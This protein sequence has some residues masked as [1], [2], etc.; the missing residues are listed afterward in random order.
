MNKTLIEMINENTEE[1]VFGNI[2]DSATQS[3]LKDYFYYRYVCDDDKFIHFFQRNLRQ[4]LRQYQQYLRV[5]NTDFDPMVTRYLE[6][7]VLNTVNNSGT[8][9]SSNATSETLTG[10]NTGTVNVKTD[11][12]T[13]TTGTEG[14]TINEN[15]TSYKTSDTDNSYSET[16][17]STGRNR[18]VF[19]SFPQANVATSTVG[20]DDN[21]TMAYATTMQDDKSTKNDTRNGTDNTDYTENGRTTETR[22]GSTNTTGNNIVDGTTLQTNNLANSQNRNGTDET[23]TTSADTSNGNLRERFTGRENYDSATLLSH[24]RDYIMNTNAFMWYVA[25]LEKCFIGNLRYGEVENE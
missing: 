16:D 25:Q 14:T 22:T 24:A 1:T 11:N 17:A 8:S 10:T 9:T 5:E 12:T 19:S 3:N 6:R 23:S 15:G 20:M 18:S 2:V 21:V 4:Y 7:Q 13:S